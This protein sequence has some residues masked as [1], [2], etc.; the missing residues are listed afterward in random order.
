MGTKLCHKRNLA[1]TQH[2]PFDVKEADRT[3]GRPEPGDREELVLP[4]EL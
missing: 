1:G 4:G 3:R 2:V